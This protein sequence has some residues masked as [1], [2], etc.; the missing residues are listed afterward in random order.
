MIPTGDSSARKARELTDSR[1]GRAQISKTHTLPGI[2]QLAFEVLFLLLKIRRLTY[3][4]RLM[5]S[6]ILL[7]GTLHVVSVQKHACVCYEH[8]KV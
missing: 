6:A 7:N 2:L 1:R 4:G 5:L 3:F 8:M